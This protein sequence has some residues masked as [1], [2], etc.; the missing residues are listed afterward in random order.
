VPVAVDESKTAEEAKGILE[1]VTAAEAISREA[2][3]MFCQAILIHNNS[4]GNKKT[5]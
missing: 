3:E 1:A 5:L 2:E 4:Q